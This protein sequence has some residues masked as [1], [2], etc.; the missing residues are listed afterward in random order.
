MSGRFESRLLGLYFHSCPVSHSV[1]RLPQDD[2]VLA[3]FALSAIY[4]RRQPFPPLINSSDKKDRC[5][6]IELNRTPRS[7]S[8]G[9]PGREP[10]LDMAVPASNKVTNKIIGYE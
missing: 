7:S 3:C 1:S 6:R 2:N 8:C 5:A 4:V 10:N 9:P